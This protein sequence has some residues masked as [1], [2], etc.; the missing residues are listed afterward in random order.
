[1]RNLLWCKC[2]AKFADIAPL[3][4]RLAVG[5]IF[6]Y[7]GYQKLTQMGIDGVAGFL[8]PMGFPMPEAFAV[9]LIAVELIGGIF[10]ILGAFTHWS[11]KLLT[12]VALVA[13]FMVHLKN[14]FPVGAGGYE[15]MMLIAAVTISLLI[16]G[17]GKYS[18][19]R[20]VFKK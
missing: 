3:V 13:L 18:V 14:G 5:S 15:F 19:D 2:A 10:L 16:T 12:V 11:A 7:H 6:A 4:L 8:G 9:I 17:P 20:M 1:M